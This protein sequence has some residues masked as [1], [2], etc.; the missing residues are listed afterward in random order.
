MFPNEEEFSSAPVHGGVGSKGYCSP[1]GAALHSGIAG[2]FC[3]SAI[4]LHD[5]GSTPGHSSTTGATSAHVTCENFV[6]GTFPAAPKAI[7]VKERGGGLDTDPY[8]FFSS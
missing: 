2:S 3:F 5:V 8:F 7:S 1:L 4:P 6:R